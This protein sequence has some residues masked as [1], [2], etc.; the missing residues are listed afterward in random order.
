M[1]IKIEINSIEELQQLKDLFIDICKCPCTCGEEP[2]ICEGLTVESLMPE[3]NT[4]SYHDVI[5]KLKFQLNKQIEGTGIITVNL[6]ISAGSGEMQEL[7]IQDGITKLKFLKNQ[8]DQY[9]QNM[10][11]VMMPRN[12]AGNYNYSLL[13][14]GVYDIIGTEVITVDNVEYRILHINTAGID[15]QA[16]IFDYSS[17]NYFGINLVSA[18]IGDTFTYNASF[19]ELGYAE[20]PIGNVVELGRVISA[21]IEVT[22][23]CGTF[24]KTL[25]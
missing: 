17:P 18:S 10:V 13:P 21:S 16:G 24:N 7:F 12:V 22:T 19:N 25:L 5:S 14:P 1:N 20:I 23:E 11:R 9:P 15:V 8:Y 3:I 6:G 2:N 4:E